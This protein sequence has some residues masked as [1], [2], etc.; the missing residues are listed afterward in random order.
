MD[1]VK[2]TPD[3]MM[4]LMTLNPLV[5]QELEKAT[6]ILTQETIDLLKERG[7]GLTYEST[8]G[9][10]IG[11]ISTFR[12]LSD[13]VV[14]N[15]IPVDACFKLEC[16]YEPNIPDTIVFTVQKDKPI[17]LIIEELKERLKSKK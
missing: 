5:I 12:A 15:E 11:Q 16:S 2:V 10:F 13:L 4:W 14:N 7:I 8:T 6:L 1:E 17:S 3:F 9:F